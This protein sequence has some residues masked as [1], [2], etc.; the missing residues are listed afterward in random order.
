MSHIPQSNRLAWARMAVPVVRRESHGANEP[1][2]KSHHDHG[3]DGVPLR[4]GPHPNGQDAEVG[5][6]K[7][8]RQSHHGAPARRKTH[9]RWHRVS[10]RVSTVSKTWIKTAWR[11]RV[12][13]SRGEKF[14][15]LV[16]KRA[17]ACTHHIVKSQCTR[18]M[19][20]DREGGETQVQRL[21]T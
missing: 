2:W 4:D 12:W 20:C 16:E 9:R 17:A 3:V 5:P 14:L 13:G 8:N 7:G 1:A 18:T 15:R 21:N 10:G 19:A 11:D 6:G